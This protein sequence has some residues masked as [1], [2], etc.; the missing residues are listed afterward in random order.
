MYEDVGDHEDDNE[1]FNDS[2][3]FYHFSILGVHLDSF[4]V[5]RHFSSNYKEDY[6]HE[7]VD[8]NL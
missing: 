1:K 3:L 5:E 7:K 2:K 4:K 6:G 8:A